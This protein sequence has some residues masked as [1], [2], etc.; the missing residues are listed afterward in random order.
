VSIAKVADSLR[1]WSDAL[2]RLEEAV[3]AQTGEREPR[4]SLILRFMLAYELAWKTF[5]RLLLE[6]GVEARSPREA[7]RHAFQRG[8]IDD[9]EV[10][11]DMIRSRNLVIHTYRETLAVEVASDIV[12]LAPSMREAWRRAKATFEVMGA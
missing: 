8:W 7:F 12:E 3:A 2:D 9:E 5:Q 10:W 6:L 1:S 4:D 11:L